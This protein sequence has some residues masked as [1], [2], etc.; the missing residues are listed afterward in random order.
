MKYV[1]QYFD[2]EAVA[3]EAGISSDP[4]AALFAMMRREE[5]S[6]DMMFELHLMRA[7]NAVREGRTTV[8]A[9]LAEEHQDRSSA[10]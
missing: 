3:S 8:E 7:C 1:P 9:I 2:Y 4:L 10:A 6:D 5:P